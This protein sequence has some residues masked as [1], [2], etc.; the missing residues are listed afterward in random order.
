MSRKQQTPA[1]CDW[2]MAFSALGHIQSCCYSF[3]YGPLTSHM[4]PTQYEMLHVSPPM[5]P[6][7]C[8]AGNSKLVDA[9]G[10]V[11]VNKRTTQH[12][13]YE[14]VFSLGDCSNIPTSKTAAAVGQYLLA[15]CL[16]LVVCAL[17][18]TCASSVVF[19]YFPSDSGRYRDSVSS[20]QLNCSLPLDFN[21][22]LTVR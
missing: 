9:A 19:N 8:L 2:N 5:S 21:L 3:K 18:S 10:F 13:S 11:D 4:I 12:V 6:Q 22:K 7:P 20:A 17:F 15:F 16:L 14:N 1:L